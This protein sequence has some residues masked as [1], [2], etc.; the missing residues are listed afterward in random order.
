MRTVAS[1]RTA[2]VSRE[3]IM[4]DR[5]QLTGIAVHANH[6]V[7]PHEAEY[8]QGFTIDITCWLDFAEAARGDDLTDTVNYAQLAQLAVDIATGTRRALIETVAAEIAE[9]AMDTFAQLHAIEVTVHKPHAPVGIT[10]DDVSVTARRS[11]TSSPVFRNA[12]A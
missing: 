4:A 12:K 9:A 8:G 7:L 6:G 3:A 1:L 5:I 2:A 10:L 11:R